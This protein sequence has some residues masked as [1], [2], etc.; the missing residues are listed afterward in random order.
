MSIAL[1]GM[2]ARTHA[3]H[4][5]S[6]LAALAL[7][8][9]AYAA[10]GDALGEE[11]VLLLDDP[12]TLLDPERRVRLVAA[13]PTGQVLITAADPSEIPPDLIASA[14]DVVEARGA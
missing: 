12:F 7:V 4:G 9:G 10:L 14:I 8:L 6:W 11:P 5:E 1:G 13:L 3:S 2:P